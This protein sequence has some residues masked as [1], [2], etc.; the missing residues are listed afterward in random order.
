VAR[1]EMI[2]SHVRRSAAWLIDIAFYFV[3]LGG[4]PF[5]RLFCFVS[6]TFRISA[7]LVCASIADYDGT[8][9]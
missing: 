1:L 9:F 8:K 2:C 7:P 6:K 5:I 4:R 3:F